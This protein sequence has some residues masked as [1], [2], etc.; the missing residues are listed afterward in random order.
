MKLLPFFQTLQ[1]KRVVVYVQTGEV[2]TGIL[3]SV[4]SFLNVKLVNITPDP[5]CT[6]RLLNAIETALI[7]GDKINYIEL[8]REEINFDILHDC[9]RRIEM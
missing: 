5:N 1:G 3:E 6:S 9:C 2:I 7:P 4:D 8:P